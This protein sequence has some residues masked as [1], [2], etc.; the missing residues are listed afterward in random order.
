M[1]ETK[2]NTQTNTPPLAFVREIRDETGLYH[3]AQH[4]LAGV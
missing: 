2:P 3:L 4:G 1:R